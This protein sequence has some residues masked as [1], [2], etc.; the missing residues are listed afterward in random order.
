MIKNVKHEER[1]KGYFLEAAKNMIRSE[2]LKS[3]SVRNIAESAGYSYATMYNYYRNLSELI[4]DCIK[5]FFGECREYISKEEIP[6]KNGKKRLIA[7]TKA[8]IK[9]FVQ[10]PGIF[11]V[12][13]LESKPIVP[14][15]PEMN[16]II[17]KFLIELLR[18]DALDIFKK[19]KKTERFLRIH[20]DY[21]SGLL[22]LYI[23]RRIPMDYKQMLEDYEEGIELIIDAC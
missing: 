13:F 2:G 7:L 15:K 4:L 1:L 23:N 10:Y 12:I 9:F 20:R 18:A 3:V 8:Y 22:L 17:E 21:V 16:D 11:E 19:D 5:D 6:E 14:F